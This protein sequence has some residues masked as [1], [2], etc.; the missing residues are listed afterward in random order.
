[1]DYYF[2]YA[3]E[4]AGNFAELVAG[5]INYH[6]VRVSIPN[7]GKIYSYD[8]LKSLM[9]IHQKTN[10]KYPVTIIIDAS[11]VSMDEGAMQPHF[12]MHYI[13]SSKKINLIA[14]FA[15]DELDNI[16]K[17]KMDESSA[18][19]MSKIYFSLAEQTLQYYEEEL[20]KTKV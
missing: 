16:T 7:Y 5:N 8:Y 19:D 2:K 14:V 12:L 4:L 3:L 11:H 1:M 13:P 18:I 17:E 10:P 6:N 20:K 15:N 9:L